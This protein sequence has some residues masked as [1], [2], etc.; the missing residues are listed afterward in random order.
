MMKCLP[1]AAAVT[2]ALAL[3]AC[4]GGPFGSNAP[5]T[6]GPVATGPMG[7][8]HRQVAAAN[9]MSPATTNYVG[10]AAT[11]N[12]YEI[13]AGRIAA[14]KARNPRVKSFA[15]MMVSDHSN[16]A[17]RMQAAVPPGVRLPSQLDAEHQAKL[18]QL[19]N[20]PAGAGFDRVYMQQQVAA[21]EE[22]LALHR[23]YAQ[24]G[25]VPALRELASSAVPVVD[26][27]L[28]QARGLAR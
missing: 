14:Q 10:D 25:D 24:S 13:E 23:S 28:R 12:M 5:N 18:T 16:T 11:G 15:Q 6:G 4:E 22:A 1:L 3:A 8:T 2:A 19:Q 21:H 7:G 17:A 27:H 26:N 9:P 20:T